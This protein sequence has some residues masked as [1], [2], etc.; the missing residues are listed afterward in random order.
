MANEI[1]IFVDCSLRNGSV[2]NDFQPS[3]KSIN[4]TNARFSDRILTIGTSEEDVDFTD[5]TQEGYVMIHNTDSTNY[6]TIG[7][8]DG[9]NMVAFIKLNAGE[10]CVF[11]I[12][13]TA[14]LRCAANTAACE[15]R[16]DC[17]DN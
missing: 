7:P 2:E 3:T 12:V 11:R 13:P 4:Q 5:L 17:F 14:V 1:S 16:F 6:V 9:G 8:K 15:V 10:F